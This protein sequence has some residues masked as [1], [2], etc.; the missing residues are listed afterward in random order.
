VATYDSGL[1]S[2]GGD[3]ARID[4]AITDTYSTCLTK[5]FDLHAGFVMRR[6]TATTVP[7]S[8]AP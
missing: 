4:I 8:A 6:S 2:G 7:L 5:Q 3:L 1:V